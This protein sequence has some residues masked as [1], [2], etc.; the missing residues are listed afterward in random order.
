MTW[1]MRP[2][3][4]EWLVVFPADGAPP[5]IPFYFSPFSLLLLA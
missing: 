5:P 3:E 2:L 4:I 1:K